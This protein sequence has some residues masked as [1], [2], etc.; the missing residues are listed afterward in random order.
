[1]IQF[2]QGLFRRRY[3]LLQATALL[4]WFALEIAGYGTGALYSLL[5]RPLT[6]AAGSRLIDLIAGSPPPGPMRLSRSERD[7][8]AKRIEAA[9]G[10]NPPKHDTLGELRFL[11][12]PKKGSLCDWRP[13]NVV[14][15]PK[16]C[17]DLASATPLFLSLLARVHPKSE[18]LYLRQ[19]TGN[20]GEPV[21]FA[22]FIGTNGKPQIL[23]D[24]SRAN[25]LKW[26]INKGFVLK[27]YSGDGLGAIALGKPVDGNAVFVVND[28]G[29]LPRRDRNCSAVACFAR[30]LVLRIPAGHG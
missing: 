22:F 27:A 13:S 29:A 20:Q 23:I 11:Y 21:I 10:G 12:Q 9:F 17:N 15:D 28:P 8:Q 6:N 14:A 24:L 25:S 19:V 5:N 3:W 16:E 26:D 18:I 30:L 1:M 2:V 4:L 7:S